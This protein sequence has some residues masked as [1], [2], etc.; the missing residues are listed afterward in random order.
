MRISKYIFIAIC[1][2]IT[3]LSFCQVLK[4]GDISI[5]TITG[6]SYSVVARIAI[7]WPVSINKPYVKINWGDASPLDSLAYGG[8]NC[9][10]FG[11]TTLYFYGNHTFAPNSTFTVSILDSFFVSNIVNIPNSSSVKMYLHSELN[12]FSIFQPNTSV[13]TQVVCLTDSAVCCNTVAYNPGATDSDGDSL[14]YSL[15][16][17]PYLNY[18]EPPVVI[19]PVTGSLS[20]TSDPT[21]FLSVSIKIDEWRMISNVYYKIASTYQELFFKIY[22]SVGLKDYSKEN[23]ELYIFPNPTTSIIN[24][25]DENNQLQNATIQIKNYLGQL[26]FTSSFTSQ[27]NFSSLS[28]GMYFLSIEDENSK[29]TI[30]IIKQ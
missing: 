20:F 4:G 16:T 13:N 1:N 17:P 30:K 26:V 14:S 22:N 23:L 27:I 7:D 11:A 19:N 12:T 25:V 3:S 10:L 28:A 9:T 15:V 2:L 18:I 21:G 6:N 8:S 29:K 24:I 5:K